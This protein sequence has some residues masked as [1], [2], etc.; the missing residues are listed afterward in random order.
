M[1][2]D[3]VEATRSYEKWMRSCTTVVESHLRHKHEQMREDLFL[4]FRGTFY[5]WAQLFPERCPDLQHAPKVLATGDLHVSSFGTW[6]DVEGR[7]SWGVDDFDE[8]FPL[9]Y[10]NDLVRLAT[11]L[12]IVNDA[13][14]LTTKFKKGCDIILEAY[15]DTLKTGG[16]PVVLAEHETILE[17]LGIDAIKPPDDFWAKLKERPAVNGAI[18]ADAKQA[19]EKMLPEPS[20]ECKIVRREAGMGSL[21]QQ[22]FVAIAEWKGGCIA[23]EAKA[24]LPSSCLWLS[25]QV[26]HHQ[27][28]YEKVMQSAVRA[29]DPFQ[30]VIGKWLIRRLSPD[31]N[32]VEIESLPASRDEE[33]L[34]HAMGSEAANV[35]LGTK[36]QSRNILHDL[37]KR[38]GDWLRS[39]AKSMAKATAREWKVYKKS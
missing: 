20:I 29:H 24:M 30:K 14:D 11:S 32:P 7:L 2:M 26:G 1:T 33:T 19:L 17:K 27:P 38:K 16:H 8:S 36:G 13:G 28:V 10:T 4:F 39:A 18:P 9:P 15:R 3:I 23:R 21:G 12:K 35:H 5:R 6:R 37:Q 22:R 34:L 31:S 25:G